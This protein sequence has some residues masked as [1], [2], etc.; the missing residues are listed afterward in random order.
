MNEG[1][2]SVIIPVYNAQNYLKRCLDSVFQ[3]NYQDIEVICVNDGSSDKSLSILNDYQER[4]PQKMVIKS[5]TNGGQANARN[6]GIEMANGKFLCFVDSD[7]AMDMSM[8]QK[9]QEHI[10]EDCDFVFCDIERIF[11][12][13]GNWLEKHFKYE[14]D[15]DFKGITTIHEHPEVICYLTVAP[16]AKLIRKSFLDGNQIRFV[17]GYIYEDLLFTQTILAANPRI[18]LLKEKLYKYFVRNNSTMTSKKSNICDMFVVINNIYKEYEKQGLTTLFKTELDYLCLYHVMIGTSYR[19]SRNGQ[20]GLFS[21]I[22][23]CRS[24][25]KEFDCRKGNKYIKSKGLV[26]RFFITFLY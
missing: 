6:V 15:L 1:L 26:A 18:S 8:L 7:D 9:M 10:K 17:K 22:K 19:M 13:D 20:Y 21:S 11:E 24:F 5:I 3:Q 12:G 16:F 4:Y 14:I 2:I 25:C 23:K